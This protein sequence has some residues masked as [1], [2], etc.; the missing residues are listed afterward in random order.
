MHQLSKIQQ[1]AVSGA[2]EGIYYYAGLGHPYQ[3]SGVSQACIDTYLSYAG[4]LPPKASI[5]PASVND[6]FN[7]CGQEGLAELTSCLDP[8]IEKA[9]SVASL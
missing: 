1:K 4:K 9:L 2:S 5:P 7:A 6:M 8:V 3:C